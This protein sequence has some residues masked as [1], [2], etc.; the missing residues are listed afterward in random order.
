MVGLKTEPFKSFYPR[1]KGEAELGIYFR[2]S[3]SRGTVPRYASV[4][5]TLR[6]NS[7]SNKLR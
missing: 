3:A 2:F 5:V 1:A 7:L 4:R 6:A